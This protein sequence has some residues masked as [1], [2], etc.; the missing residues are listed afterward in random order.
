MFAV[1]ELVK[2]VESGD[3][4]LYWA[5]AVFTYFKA[6]LEGAAVTSATKETVA[7]LLA[8]I[9]GIEIPVVGLADVSGILLTITELDL[10]V[11][12]EG[13]VSVKL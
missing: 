4:K 13:R 7:L 8:A 1:T 5:V 9:V 11:K 12:P 3:S 10:K 2:V 6:P